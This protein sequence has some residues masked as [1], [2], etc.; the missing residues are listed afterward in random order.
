MLHSKMNPLRYRAYV[1][2]EE[3]GLY[4]IS[5]RYYNPEM[6]RFISADTTSVL[7]MSPTSLNN[8]NL[9][10]YCDNNPVS[11]K[12]AAGGCWITTALLSCGFM[13]AGG[14][15]GAAVSAAVSIYTQDKFDGGVNWESVVVAAGSGFV[16][17]AMAASPLSVE[18]QIAGGAAISALSYTADCEVNHKDV[19]ADELAIAVG[20]GMISGALGGDGANI[21]FGLAHSVE[22][23]M[24]KITEL[25]AKKQ[26]K[27]IAKSIVREAGYMSNKLGGTVAV[28]SAAF[29]GLTFASSTFAASYTKVRNY[30]V[31]LLRKK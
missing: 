27:Y 30:F 7:T 26:T 4:Y 21:N 31:K 2:D 13:L 11:R 14:V 16:S 3:T 12:D 5:N 29:S 1:Y 18:W 25:S 19:K 22:Q 6:G 23:S 9:F 15:I 8:K 28:N 24:K 20:T 10:A 17:G